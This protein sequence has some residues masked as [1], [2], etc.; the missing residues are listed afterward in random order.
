[1]SDNQIETLG[2]SI[3]LTS[4][5]FIGFLRWGI[6][7]YLYEREIDKIYAQKNYHI[8]EGKIY[9]YENNSRPKRHSIIFYVDGIKFNGRIAFDGE[10]SNDIVVRIKYASKTVKHGENT[11]LEIEDINC[12]LPKL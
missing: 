9:N 10:L 2:W 5:F 11:I 1:M 7:S 8:V 3:I 4:I 6:I 12:V